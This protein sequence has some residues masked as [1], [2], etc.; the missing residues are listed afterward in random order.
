MATAGTKGHL[1]KKYLSH[2]RFLDVLKE[3][4]NI[5]Q[6]NQKT[7]RSYQHKLYNID[8]RRTAL[9]SIDDKRYVLP[10]G[11]TRAL[12]HHK[13]FNLSSEEELFKLFHEVDKLDEEDG[14]SS[15]S[16]N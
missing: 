4:Q 12:G 16:R 1:A 13:N 2:Q 11:S 6:I 15:A 7:I 14:S 8:Q 9:S 5:I 10:D 3:T